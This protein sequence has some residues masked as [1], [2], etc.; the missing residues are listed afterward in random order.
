LRGKQNSSKKN[1]SSCRFVH[2]SS[3]KE[4][5]GAKPSLCRKIRAIY[6][7][8]FSY[9]IGHIGVFQEKSSILVLRVNVRFM[10]IN[11]TKHIKACIRNRKATEMKTREKN[12]LLPCD[13]LRLTRCAIL[14]LSSSVLEPMVKPRRTEMSV[15][16]KIFGTLRTNL[17]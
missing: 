10:Y 16:L 3:H 1:I 5:S 6:S 2:H 8:P 12:G 14:T 11:T 4:L 7:R 15:L 13:I 17:C 9:K